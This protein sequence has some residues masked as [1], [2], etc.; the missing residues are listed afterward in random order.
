[1]LSAREE[2]ISMR[3][4]FAVGEA[5]DRAE[6]QAAFRLRHQ[7]FR[8]EMSNSLDTPD[9]GEEERDR[10]DDHA[11]ILVVRDNAAQGRVIGT[12]RVLERNAKTIAARAG[13]TIEVAH[14]ASRRDNRPIFSRSSL[15][16]SHR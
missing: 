15:L 10:F 3:D 7:V 2:I 9:A 11:R 4:R 13:H 14:I 1:M 5:T 6:R 8:Q 16:S 12:Y